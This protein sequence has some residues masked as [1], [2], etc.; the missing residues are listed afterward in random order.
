MAA[1]KPTSPAFPGFKKLSS[2]I[3]LY[4]PSTVSLNGSLSNGSLANGHATQRNITT[5]PPDTIII[6]GW[7]DGS[8]R[9]VAKYTDA[10]QKLYPTARIIA[11]LSRT[12][13]IFLSSAEETQ[14]VMKPAVTALLSSDRLG[15]GRAP[16]GRVLLHCLSNGGA[17]NLVGF[18]QAYQAETKTFLPH[19]LLVTDSTPGGD[20]FSGELMNW[21]RGVTGGMIAHLPFKYMPRWLVLGLAVVWCVITIGVPTIFGVTNVATR[22]RRSMNDPVLMGTAKDGGERIYLYGDADEVIGPHGVESHARESEALGW[23]VRLEKFE[24]SAHVA[25]ARTHPEQYWGAVTG[26]WEE[27]LRG[28]K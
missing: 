27:A 1:K 9:H 18:S 4:E 21:A 28:R 19:V 23:R 6:F 5:P 15:D 20:K 22:C 12:M 3:Y 17:I 13:S 10:Y 26:A 8:P 25:H 16:P 7:A 11:I 24:G 2:K 14:A